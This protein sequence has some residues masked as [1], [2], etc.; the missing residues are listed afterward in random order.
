MVLDYHGGKKSWY[1]APMAPLEKVETGLKV[2]AILIAA[3][4][5]LQTRGASGGTEVAGTLAIQTR[6]MR[7]MAIALAIAIL[8]RL[9]QRE[10]VSIAFVVFND[11]AH[12][13]VYF[14][15]ASG[16]ASAAGLVA[17][18]ALMMAGDITKIVFFAT[19]EYTVRRVPKPLLLA[20]VAA[21]VV[22]YG[23]VLVLAV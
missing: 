19:T 4:V 20:G 6:I 16:V 8:D 18:C 5:F 15:L 9:Q 13:G 10:L 17:Y 2:I 1:V 11:L 7:V 21:F 22:A 23:V 14:A 12:W 3:A